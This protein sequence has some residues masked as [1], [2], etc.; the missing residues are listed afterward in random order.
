MSAT[1]DKDI[2]DLKAQIDDLRND[3]SGIADALKK[4]S[5]SA[6]D[7]GTDRV[8]RA[9]E[10]A[11]DKARDTIGAFESE[12]EERPLTSVATAFGIGFILGKLLDS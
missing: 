5:G 7:E 4:L 3:L 11:R 8:R 10:K 2:E 12:I 1:T 9:S 6:V